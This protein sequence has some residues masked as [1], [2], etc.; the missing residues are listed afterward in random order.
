MGY[1]I[2]A[3]PT[4]VAPNVTSNTT[5]YSPAC[6][7]RAEPS[8]FSPGPFVG[9]DVLLLPLLLVPGRV[10]DPPLPGVVLA[11]DELVPVAAGASAKRSADWNGV[12]ELVAGRSVRPGLTGFWSSPMQLSNTPGRYAPGTLTRHPNVSNTCSHNPNAFGAFTSHN[13]MQNSSPPTK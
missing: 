8:W 10:E 5:L 1:T 9:V 7:P 2:T 13:F 3:A 4:R 6:I 11:L 12:H